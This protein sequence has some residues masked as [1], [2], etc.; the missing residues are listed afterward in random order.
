VQG[1]EKGYVQTGSGKP[2][3]LKESVRELEKSVEQVMGG[4]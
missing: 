1:D 3:R 4:L 2:R